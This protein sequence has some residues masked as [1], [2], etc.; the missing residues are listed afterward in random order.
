M[1]FD[2]GH[3]LVIGVGEYTHH[4]QANVSM[5]AEDARQVAQVLAD[6]GLC[7]YPPEQVALLKNEDANRDAVRKALAN[8]SNVGEDDTVLL[9]FSGHGAL[10]DDGSYYL[11]TCDSQFAGGRVVNGTGI[12]EGELLQY[13]YAVPARKMILLI[14]ACFSGE[15]SP[16]FSPEEPPEVESAG[17]PNSAAD[18][19]LGSG[20]GRIIITSSRHSQ[21][22]WAKWGEPTSFFGRALVDGLRGEGWVANNAGYIGAFGLYEYVYETVKEAAEEI[23]QQQEPV[24]TVLQGVGPFPLA[25]YRGA[26]AEPQAF[27]AGEALPEELPVRRIT[28]KASKRTF[29]KRVI[30]TGGGAYVE[31]N[32]NTG[33]GDFVG[34]DKN[35][36]QANNINGI[37]VVGDGNVINTSPDP[38]EIAK[39]QREKARRAY[40]TELRATCN[41]LPLAAM[42]EDEGM[43]ADI[44]LDHIYIALDTT[45]RIKK[46]KQEK[47]KKKRA[48]EEPEIA[49]PGEEDVRTISAQEAAAGT[50]RLVLLGDPGAGKSTFVHYLAAWLAAAGL[51]EAVKPIGID[52]SLTPILITLRYLAP[53]LNDPDYEKQPADWQKKYLLDALDEQIRAELGLLGGKALQ[54]A[55]GLLED[56]S[57]GH[58]LLVLDG[59]DEVPNDLRERVHQAVTVVIQRYRVERIII[60]CRIRSYT[61]PAAFAGFDEYR[62]APF[63]E[64]KIRGFAQAWYNTQWN[65]KKIP[66]KEQADQ[67]AGDLAQAT[68]ALEELA[69]NPMLLT[70]MAIIH[71]RD[72]GLPDQRVKLYD[73][74]VEVLARR[75]QKHKTGEQSPSKAL[76]EILKDSRR[77]RE[78]LERL[79][80]EAHLASASQER[81][82]QTGNLLRTRALEILEKRAYLGGPGLASEFLDYVDQ[83]AG[84]LAGYGGELDRPTAYGFPH[85]SLQEYLAGCYLVSR[86]DLF[87]T[88]SQHAQEGEGWDLAVE[89]GLEELYYNRRSDHLLLDLA[90]NISARCKAGN[91]HQ[92]RM[93]LWSGQAA[94]LVGATTIREDRDG[95]GGG[96]D[97]LTCIRGQLVEVMA[98]QLPSIERC[99]AGNILAK[100][101]DHRP[102]VM[103]VEG[104]RFCFVPAGPFQ[105]G[106]GKQAH[107]VDLPGFWSGQFPVTNVQFDA[108]VEAGGYAK[109]AYWQAA[110]QAGCW[111]DGFFKGGFDDEGRAGRYPIR[112]MFGLPNHPVVGVTWYEALAFT[113]WL[114]E[115][116]HQ[117]GWLEAN[118]KISLPSEAEW[119]KAARG[120][121]HVP[122]LDAAHPYPSLPLT[123]GLPALTDLCLI[124]NPLK[125][126]A[127]PWGEDFDP[128]KANT[129]ES[130]VGATS[131]V[132]CYPAGSSPYGIQEMSGNVWEWMRSAYKDYPYNP[133]DGRENHDEGA[134]RV[135][136]G[137]SWY[138]DGGFARC[139]ARYRDLPYNRYYYIGFRVVVLPSSL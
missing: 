112:G 83:R 98:G 133:S 80:Y 14:H 109:E 90:Y 6:E 35:I 115:F 77:L 15:L 48:S 69:S 75:W 25:L 18:A 86:R 31:G 4:P 23:D 101:G 41:A 50:Q 97:Y 82:D 126:R 124:E 27:D 42:G 79:G 120:G 71:Q 137:G 95:P 20:E 127:F 105:M 7:G 107:T 66:G 93:L 63:D 102:E 45:T 57:G 30:H 49:M 139:A 134:S 116:A 125:H 5:A 78:I 56:L 11:T 119:E 55:D 10:G 84:L 2:H 135:L 51:G 104:M 131:A 91:A 114:N 21:K 111:K 34:R 129:D 72:I 68:L 12:S 81:R 122:K 17:L 13:L 64:K 37:A 99:E 60:T 103:T 19:I 85:R 44:T 117:G 46:E 52:P 128:N 38:E 73:L 32:V 123:G 136:R 1:A 47:T 53:R 33:G 29:E 94:A 74:V 96:E 62:L 58:C 92:Q 8:L 118:R 43:S 138:S 36:L 24:L 113:Q 121:Q 59:L 65:L 87:N 40:L 100:L 106:E 16:S 110:R 108:F 3:A 22:S 54:Y 9:F 132:G 88:L 70:S 28:K 76:E 130:G 89:L 26:S 39:R 67:R 61:G